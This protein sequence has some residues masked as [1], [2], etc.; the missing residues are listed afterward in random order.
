MKL[1]V[2]ALVAFGFLVSVVAAD[3][4][5][6]PTLFNKLDANQDG[7]IT[8]DEIPEEGKRL[9]ERMLRTNDKNGDGELT[10]AE[11]DASITEKDEPKQAIAGQVNPRAG[12]QIDPK[13]LFARLDANK[14]G[15][16][17]VEEFPA[18]R[19]ERIRQ[20][21]PRLDAD[22]DL[23]LNEQEFG[24]MFAMFQG[25]APQ[26]KP[27]EAK[28][29]PSAM[30]A[31]GGNPLMAAL[32]TNRDGT[33]DAK[34]MESATDALQSLDRNDDGKIDA[35]ELGMLRPP[36][37]ANQAPNVDFFL[38]RVM[39]SDANGDGKLSAE[40]APDRMKPRFDMMDRNS[41]GLIDEAELKAMLSRFMQGRAKK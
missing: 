20:A 40:E 19:Q 28:P 21:L 41:D 5:L 26:K 16:V 9:F 34:E 29:S 8:A 15:K 24:R 12:R 3:A 32:D 11:F 2:A 37:M 31:M 36:M 14:D 18:E 22:G 13:Q 33:I 17:S 27:A 10:K 30:P 7:T 4:P 6:D 38:K 39:Q 23:M 35:R 1:S 25:Q